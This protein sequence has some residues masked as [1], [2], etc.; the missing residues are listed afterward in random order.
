MW[1]ALL[2]LIMPA[3]LVLAGCKTT[4]AGYESAPY[5]VVRSEGKFQVRDYADLTAVETLMT[6]DSRDGSDG[7][8]TRLFRFISG[9]C[10]Q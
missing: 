5:K 2:I 1:I 7:S 3:A 6:P 4:R 8:V 10:S 9:S